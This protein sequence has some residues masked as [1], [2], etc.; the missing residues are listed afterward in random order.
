MPVLVLTTAFVAAE[1]CCCVGMECVICLARW[2]LRQDWNWMLHLLWSLPQCDDIICCT[3]RS[4]VGIS[5][6]VSS[7]WQDRRQDWNWILHLLWSLHQSDDIICW[8]CMTVVLI[9]MN[10]FILLNWL[11]WIHSWMKTTERVHPLQ[12][13]F[14]QP[15]LQNYLLLP[16]SMSLAR[17]PWQL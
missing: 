14:V 4:R 7:A 5:T 9:A 1:G 17:Q 16:G 12:C 11:P 6:K 3:W 15:L 10:R 13:L 8:T 2:R